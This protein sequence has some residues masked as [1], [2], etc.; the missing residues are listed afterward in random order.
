MKNRHVFFLAILVL[1]LSSNIIV[2]AQ[3]TVPAGESYQNFAA[4]GAW[5]WFADPRVVIHKS[6]IY[7]GWVDSEGN[8]WVSSMNLDTKK[9]QQVI[10]HEKFNKD[11]HANPALLILPDDR[12]MVFYSTHGGREQIGM[13]YR[14]SKFPQNISSWSD[15]Y[16]IKT[17]SGGSRGFCYPNPVLLS[18]E[19]NRIYLFWR[20]GNYKPTFTYTDNFKNWAAAQ[21]LI[22]SKESDRVRPYVKVCSDGKDRIH[23]AFTDGH[24]LVEPTNSIYYVYYEKE[25]YYRTD[26]GKIRDKRNLPIQHNEVD[27]VYDGKKDS[28]RAWIWDIALDSDKRPVIVYSRLPKQTEHYYYYACW[29]GEK[30]N[31]SKICI[32][33][34][35]FPETPEGKEEREVHYSGGVVLDHSDPKIVYLSRQIKGVFEIEKWITKNNG[36]SWKSFP[37]TANSKNNNV[38]P[39][40]IRNHER[41]KPHVMWMNNKKYVHYTDYKSVI[42]MDLLPNNRN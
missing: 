16:I 2:I 7:G 11:D 41:R 37:I 24:P 33:G 1:L 32:A 28:V 12:I 20:G 26:G 4:N 21:T 18:N 30:W 35:W 5:C 34:K 9:K 38:R 6:N 15:E 39:F 25:K 40:V 36:K 31:D 42:K 8:I 13:H 19:K 17:N 14:I 3:E 22:Q 23:F 10:L 29:D 27:L